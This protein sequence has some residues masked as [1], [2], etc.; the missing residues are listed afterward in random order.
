MYKCIH[1][2]GE[3]LQRFQACRLGCKLCPHY[4]TAA[5]RTTHTW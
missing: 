1:L 2:E 5:S 4:I 3:A